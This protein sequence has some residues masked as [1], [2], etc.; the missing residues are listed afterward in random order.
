[1]AGAA[2]YGCTA[3]EAERVENRYGEG[4][5]VLITAAIDHGKLALTRA[6][7][8]L[9]TST[10]FSL[11]T[12]DNGNSEIN[13]MVD[14][15]AGSYTGYEY[16]ITAATSI[17]APATPP[18]FPAGVNSVN[19]YGW[20]PYN[21]GN[22]SFSVQDDQTSN[23]N[24]CLSDLMLAQP[25]TCTRA[26]NAGVWNV[27]PAAL[28]F[29]HA[30]A[31]MKVTLDPSAGVSITQV[32]LLNVQKT[33]T[34]GTTGSPVVT[35]VSIGAASGDAGAIT[36]FSGGTITSAS[37]AAEK[38]VCCVFPPQTVAAGNLLEITANSGGQQSTITYS[39]DAQKAFAANTPYTITATVNKVTANATVSIG[40]WSGDEAVTV[41]PSVNGL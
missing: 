11:L 3:D 17:A 40:N 1:M 24:Y 9:D 16:S 36:M 6:A 19:V 12:A 10:G 4:D 31:K 34:I 5:E 21:S 29:N 14:N 22:T 25:A 2:L 15:G 37:T 33:V 39:M 8:G 38:T 18:Y 28:T 7:D 27:T 26:L 41:T 32:R 23:A 13:I 35:A 30:L 20:Y